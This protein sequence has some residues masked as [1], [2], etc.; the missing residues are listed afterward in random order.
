MEHHRAI[1]EDTAL[2]IRG[3]QVTG[4]RQDQSGRDSALPIPLHSL[5]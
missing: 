4:V 3:Q 1:I 5:R 2:D